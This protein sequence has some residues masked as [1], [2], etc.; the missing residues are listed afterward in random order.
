MNT[1]ASPTTTP[2]PFSNYVRGIA[3]IN[4]YT[5]QPNSA[6]VV[7][8]SSLLILWPLHLKEGIHKCKKKRKLYIKP[9]I[10]GQR[11]ERVPPLP[12]IINKMTR[13]TWLQPHMFTLELVVRFAIAFS[14]ASL[15]LKISFSNQKMFAIST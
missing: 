7:A 14:H 6:E 2:L 1:E 5:Y 8:L 12:L 15:V 3:F 9:C 4:S 11:K 13:R 10:A